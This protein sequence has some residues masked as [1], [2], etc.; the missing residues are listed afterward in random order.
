VFKAADSSD[1]LLKKGSP[2]TH[3][4]PTSPPTL[5]FHGR[6]DAT[7]DYL[8]SEELARVLDQNN[9]PHQLHLLD[10]I[11]HTFAFQTWGKKKLPQDLRPLVFAFLDQYLR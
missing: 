4:T 7:V 6:T 11:G 10:G 1:P 3:I 8:Q 9:V 5:I 2:V